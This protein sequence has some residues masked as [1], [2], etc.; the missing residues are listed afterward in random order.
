MEILFFVHTHS[1]HW[2]G[3][4]DSCTKSWNQKG[5]GQVLDLVKCF[6]N[7]LEQL[8]FLVSSSYNLFCWWV[9]LVHIKSLYVLLRER[10]RLPLPL[11]IFFPIKKGQKQTIE[12]FLKTGV[13]VKLAI[14]LKYTCDRQCFYFGK[15][16]DSRSATLLEMNFSTKIL[17]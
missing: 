13:A 1:S 7:G 10:V 4:F 16:A 9:Q 8:K 6:G 11:L 5:S 12:L 14:S 3:P 15:V 17:Q 2:L